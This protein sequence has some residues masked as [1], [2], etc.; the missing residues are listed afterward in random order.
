MIV[1]KLASA[2]QQYPGYA[3][4]ITGHSLGAALA[5]LAA[6]ELRTQGYSMALVSIFTQR[7]ILQLT[8]TVWLWLSDGRKRS[9]C[10]FC[11]W[12]GG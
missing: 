11:H 8:I 9:I 1:S 12:S 3:V 4:V 7:Y 6:A 2:V 10:Q 5:T